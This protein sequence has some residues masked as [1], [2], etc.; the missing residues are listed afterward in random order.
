MISLLAKG[1]P[2]V[3]MA[4]WLE[5]EYYLNVGDAGELLIDDRYVFVRKHVYQN[6][7]GYA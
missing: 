3:I 5:H 1:N 2:N 7:T 4:L 6:F